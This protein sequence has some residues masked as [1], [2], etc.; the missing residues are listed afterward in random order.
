MA[1]PNLN[2]QEITLDD[3]L[4]TDFINKINNNME[5]IDTKYS[6]LKNGVLE[7]TGKGTLEES[8]AFISELKKANDSYE[9]FGNATSSDILVG[10]TALVKG[11]EVTGQLNVNVCYVSSSEPS[12]GTGNNGDLWL[13]AEGG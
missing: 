8:I 13:V 11:K 3:K 10:K 9:A 4:R 7:K 12:N 6:E 1:T 2:L 5:I